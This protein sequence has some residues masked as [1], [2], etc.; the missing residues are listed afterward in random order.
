MKI[1]D[2][3]VATLVAKKRRT[4][5]ITEAHTGFESTEFNQSTWAQGYLGGKKQHRLLPYM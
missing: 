4:P 5:W 2:F 1:Q 3:D